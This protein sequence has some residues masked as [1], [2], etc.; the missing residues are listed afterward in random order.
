MLVLIGGLL[1][2]VIRALRGTPAGP[3]HLEITDLNDRYRETARALKHATLSG[4]ALRKA[5]R[6][7]TK[8]DKARDKAGR[9][10][11]GG[12]M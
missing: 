10:R 5:V 3:E 11:G 9:G 2:V 4:K 1:V 12:S 6:A 7:E 8:E